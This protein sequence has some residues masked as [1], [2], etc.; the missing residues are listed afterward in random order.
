MGAPILS[1]DLALPVPAY[2]Q[3]V[4]GLR[5]LL[6]DGDAPAP[7]ERLPTVRRLAADL[8]IHHNTVAQAY[9]VL[10]DEGWLELVRGR[11]AVVRE[12][13]TP[14]PAE[15]ARDAFRRRLEALVSEGLGQGL[16][17]RWLAAELRLRGE[18]V[19]GEEERS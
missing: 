11:G 4:D 19:G 7:G 17:R 5:A 9:R 2:R 10:E 16:P 6:L 12:R 15:A 8:G 3:I 14:E 13:P 18:S 1:I